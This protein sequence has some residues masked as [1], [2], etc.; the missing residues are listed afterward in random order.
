MVRTPRSFANILVMV[1]REY[2]LS[3]ATSATVSAG[4]SREADGGVGAPTW[5]AVWSVM[6]RGAV[7]QAAVIFSLSV[8][9]TAFS[10]S[11]GGTS[12]TFLRSFCGKVFRKLIAWTIRP[13]RRSSE[14]QQRLSLDV[15]AR[16][17]ARTFFSSAASVRGA[18]E[19]VLPNGA[20]VDVRTGRRRCGQR[21]AYGAPVPSF[22]RPVASNSDVAL[23]CL[24]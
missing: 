19:G 6:E 14:D 9:S 2:P 4:L 8:V 11:A 18:V 23:V 7:V 17:A 12:L 13:S 16:D 10:T 3:S 20:G 22:I 5:G 15:S 24:R 1:W 21:D